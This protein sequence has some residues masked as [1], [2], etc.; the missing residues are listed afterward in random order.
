MI[1]YIKEL[2]N[3]V[4]EVTNIFTKPINETPVE[5][6]LFVVDFYNNYSDINTLI[7]IAE[8]CV[9]EDVNSLMSD[10]NNLIKAFDDYLSYEKN[11]W[12]SIGL[13]D[14]IGYHL[15]KRYNKYL[16][17]REEVELFEKHEFRVDDLGTLDEIVEQ[18]SQSLQE[19]ERLENFWKE[20]KSKYEGVPDLKFICVDTIIIHLN[21]AVRAIQSDLN[22]LVRSV[23]SL[24]LIY[25]NS[26]VLKKAALK[27]DI[28]SSR[29]CLDILEICL[30]FSVFENKLIPHSDFINYLNLKPTCVEIKIA[31]KKKAYVTVFCWWI[32]KITDTHILGKDWKSSFYSKVKINKNYENRHVYDFIQRP[33]KQMAEYVKEIEDLFRRLYPQKTDGLIGRAY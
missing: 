15:T 4:I 7:D 8:G 33:S 10:L 30:K 17:K 22:I 3:K 6:A 2:T 20:E 24:R 19:K 32:A 21:E 25:S 28:V 11:E 5:E 26:R 9:R 14:V 16:K 29:L 18:Y 27:K 23:D 31:N 1:A 12:L 13:H